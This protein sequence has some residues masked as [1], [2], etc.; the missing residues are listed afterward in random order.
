MGMY[1]MGDGHLIASTISAPIRV[2]ANNDVPSGAAYIPF[3]LNTSAAWEGW[4]PD[5]Q[6]R[7]PDSIR[8]SGTE[9][10]RNYSL[11][12]RS[13]DLRSGQLLEPCCHWELRVLS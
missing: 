1:S 7:L 5:M 2:L 4:K 3:T 8:S 12:S 6:A 13:T 9:S 11:S 10:E